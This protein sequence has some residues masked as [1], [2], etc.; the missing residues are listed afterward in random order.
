MSQVP[1]SYME[2]VMFNIHEFS[3]NESLGQDVI[4]STASVSGVRGHMQDTFLSPAGDTTGMRERDRVST[5]RLVVRIT[6]E[7]KN[8]IL[9]GNVVTITH[10]KNYRTKGW[11]S[12]TAGSEQYIINFDSDS[13]AHGNYRV[14]SLLTKNRS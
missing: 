9:N 10:K 2:N 1:N 6:E 7:N 14:L 4:N 13:F 3:H 11:D 8:Y 5:V 12:V